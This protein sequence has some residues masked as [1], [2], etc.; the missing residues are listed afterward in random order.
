M[1]DEREQLTVQSAATLDECFEE[2][3][4]EAPCG[5]LT[6]RPDGTIVR[7]NA[8]FLA[9]TGYAREQLLDGRRFD[10]LLTVGGRI[11]NETH[12]RPLLLMQGMVREIAVEIRRADGSRLP[13]LVNAMLKRDGEGQPLSIRTIVFDASDRRRYERELLSARDRERAERER[14]AEVAHVLQDS[15]LERLPLRDARIRVGAH[16]RPAV[17]TLEVGGDWHDAFPIDG[18]GVALVVGDVVGRGIDAA[19][20][21][22]Q[23]RS[24]TRALAGAGLDG[25]SAVIAALDRFA[26]RIPRA[27]MATLAYVE[28]DLAT[29][30]ARYVCAGHPP[31]L[32]ASP[33]SPPVVLWD[34]RTLPLGVAGGS[35]DVVDATVQLAPGA[36]LLLYTDGLVERRDE[37]L[38]RGLG[39]VTDA[40]GRLRGQP[41]QEFADALVTT[42]LEGVAG[43]DDVCVLCA[44]LAP[45]A[46]QVPESKAR[47]TATRSG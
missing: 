13:V 43:R 23:L 11:Y 25:P 45:A 31:P 10:E 28:I 7:V 17:E 36:R 39:R 21:M 35:R 4:E 6:M 26:A 9:W 40:M 12:I 20:A 16:Y 19:T 44:D 2:L 5:F 15:M 27:L 30:V 29:G 3:F 8:T 37:P 34:G 42:A 24:A 46:T 22:G 38:D 1:A 18:D 33:G 32:L 47:T 41:P 14:E